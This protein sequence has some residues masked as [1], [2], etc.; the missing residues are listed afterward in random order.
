[1]LANWLGGN[2]SCPLSKSYDDLSQF[3]REYKRFFGAPSRPFNLGVV[4]RGGYALRPVQPAHPK[5]RQ[6]TK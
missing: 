3:N 1:M 2:A 4:G 5:V 6:A